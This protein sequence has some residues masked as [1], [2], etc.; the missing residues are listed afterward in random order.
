M[1][2]SFQCRPCRKTYS[3]NEVLGRR[4]CPVC[5]GPLVSQQQLEGY[6]ANTQASLNRLRNQSTL[7]LGGGAVVAMIVQAVIQWYEQK[8]DY[9]SDFAVLTCTV[10]AGSLAS[11]VATGIWWKT[12]TRTMMLVASLI[13]QLTAMVYAISVFAATSP[14]LDMGHSRLTTNAI[15][16]VAFSPLGLALLAWHQYRS[17][18]QI[19]KT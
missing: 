11:L 18:V 14:L 19:L 1:S 8:S 16:I 4:S 17:Y 12:G 7:T 9:S 10:F 3:A 2:D 13:F 15:M 5:R 6:R